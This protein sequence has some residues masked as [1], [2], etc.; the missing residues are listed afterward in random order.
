MSTGL[1]ALIALVAAL[2]AIALIAATLL[3]PLNPGFSLV[4][5]GLWTAAALAA[6]AAPVR[7]PRGVVIAVATCPILAAAFLGGPAAG[8]WV[9]LVGTL[10]L[11]ELRR[12]I[13]WYGTLYNHAATV[14]PAVLGG[15]LYWLLV[16]TGSFQAT[17]ATLAAAVLFGLIFFAVNGVLVSLSIALRRPGTS[18][19]S[20]FVS[21]FG[22]V[23]ASFIALSPL[24][25]LMAT[26]A[27]EVG[28]WAVLPF[29]LPLATT[30]GAYARVVEIREMFTQTIRSLSAAVD[31]KDKF[32]SGHSARVQEISLEI[33]R[34]MRCSES[35]LEA[36]EWGGLLHDIG[37]IG[38]PDAVLLKP[39]RLTRDE[40]ILMNMHPV[41]G[42]EIIRPVTRLAPELPIIRH[43]H[44][45]FNGSGYP[46]KLIGQ[47][48]P[49]LAR[50][51]H[52]ADAFEAMTAAR[53]YRMTPLTHEQAMG[54]LRKFAGIQFDPQMVDAFSRTRYVADVHDAGRPAPAQPIPLLSQV[55]AMRA[56]GTEGVRTESP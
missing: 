12:D 53:P 40:R 7:L 20:V 48:I 38:V 32:T 23:A 36:L 33:G 25:W 29:G 46:D 6:S 8:A 41:L 51:L 22:L 30:R 5:L 14:L 54:E 28:V 4:D 17:P 10:E 37:K 34:Q 55:A 52:V 16:P 18:L 42:E 44:E 47:D 43:H 15:S 3:F 13:P 2:S 26:V 49:K 11:R 24:A 56:S 35:E 39:D 9:A 21:D 50:I 1:K 19:R 45:W 27:V 31:K